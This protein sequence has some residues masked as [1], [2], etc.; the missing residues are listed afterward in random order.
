M[1][2]RTYELF[3][4]QD[5]YLNEVALH[6]HDFYE[7]YVFL[8]GSV[9]YS[10]ENHQYHLEEGDILLISPMQ[11]H[12]PMIHGET[13]RYERFVLWIDK[14]YLEQYRD[15]GADLTRCFDT[16]SQDY[17]NLIRPDGLSRQFLIFLLEQ[18]Q[19]ESDTEQ[20]GAD[21]FSQTYLVQIM[22]LLNRLAQRR[23]QNMDIR[24]RSESVVAAI[25]TYI[26]NHY[27]EDLSLDLL[28]NK[29][30]VSKYHLSRE[31]NRLVGTSVYRYIIQKRLAVAK[32]LMSEGVPSTTVYQQCGFGDYSNFYRAFKAEYQISPKEFIAQLRENQQR[33][34]ERN[35]DRARFLGDLL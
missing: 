12:Q 9:N 24:D 33:A 14:T 15:F 7:V 4:Y 35:R 28:A 32:Q 16:K 31:F 6:H 30:F 29:F 2:N 34:S 23:P 18:L 21:L 22:I 10:V 25:I 13:Q 17:S 26:N 19:Q 20:F 5:A 11:L 8:S 27:G 1:R 3:R